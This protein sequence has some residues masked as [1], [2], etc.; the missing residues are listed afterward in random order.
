MIEASA[1][2]RPHEPG[3]CIFCGSG[4]IEG[5][6]IEIEGKKAYQ[7]MWCLACENPW[8]DVYVLTSWRRTE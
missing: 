6:F 2:Y 8:E 3:K 4:D 1:Y 7:K 5:G